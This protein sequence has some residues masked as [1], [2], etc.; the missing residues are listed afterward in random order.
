MNLDRRRRSTTTRPRF[1]TH[2]VVVPA[3]VIAMVASLLFYL[4][5]VRSAFLGGGPQ[6]KWIG[7][8]F[9]AATVLIE[10]YGHREGDAISRGATRAAG[11][12]HGLR[13]AGRALGDPRGGTSARRSPTC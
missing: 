5:D 1:L 3:A 2:H 7:F 8:C 10:R 12:R 9:A 13:D 6:L 11:R 4:V